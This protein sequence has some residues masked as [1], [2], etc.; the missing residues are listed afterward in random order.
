MAVKKLRIPPLFEH[1]RTGVARARAEQAWA[2]FYDTGTGKTRMLL[3]AFAEEAHAAAPRP[4]AGLIVAPLSILHP[5]WQQDFQTF[6][7]P[8]H[9][10][11]GFC[12]L[13]AEQWW[14][15]CDKK[16]RGLAGIPTLLCAVNYE[17]FVREL[18]KLAVLRAWDFVV[19]D[20]SSRLKNPR[21]QVTKRAW[22]FV[23]FLRSKHASTRVYILSGTP[24]PNTQLEYFA[25]IRLLSKKVFGPS[26]Y[27]FRSRYFYPSGYMGHEWKPQPEQQPYFQQ[28]LA[29][30]SSAVSKRDCLDLPPELDVIRELDMNAEQ[31]RL[32]RQ[33]AKDLVIE[34]EA[35]EAAVARNH[36]AKILRLRQITSG[37]LLPE[38]FSEDE[39]PRN[40]RWF[41]DVKLNELR[42]VLEESGGAQ[43]VVW[44]QFHAEMARLQE[45]L[46]HYGSVGELTGRVSPATR[47]QTVAD[48]RAGKLRYLVAHPAS[49]GHGLTLV[50]ASLAIHYSLSYSWELHKQSRDRLHRAGQRNAVTNVYL[51]CKR[52][53]DFDLLEALRRKRDVAEVVLE[54][55]R[56][57]VKR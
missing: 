27:A 3:E 34:F 56:A 26:F 31:Q 50:E 23:D 4:Y 45:T 51:L 43:A 52:S 36:L 5:A 16:R 46:R 44:A 32:Y 48:F 8:R 30:V 38:R 20:E 28:R 35:M 10:Q 39:E 12:D 19:F 22:A 9:P 6:I 11:W 49:A 1:Q 42:A 37:F 17:L 7:H 29:M 57:R 41:S 18:D 40:L 24:A 15:T 47:N 53:I 54:G 33:M 13:H 2:F 55:L 21:A 14:R 25:Q